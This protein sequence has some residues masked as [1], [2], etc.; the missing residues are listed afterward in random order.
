MV[1]SRLFVKLV[2]SVV[3]PRSWV[4][5]LFVCHVVCAAI[6]ILFDVCGELFGRFIIICYGGIRD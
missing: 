2:T 4:S 6:A 3:V 5:V 1:G